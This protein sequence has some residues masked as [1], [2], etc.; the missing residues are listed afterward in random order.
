MVRSTAGWVVAIILILLM[1]G[2]G[3]LK[4]FPMYHSVFF[5]HFVLVPFHKAAI[6]ELITCRDVGDLDEPETGYER[7]PVCSWW[8]CAEGDCGASDQDIALV[9]ACDVVSVVD[10]NC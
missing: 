10:F 6:L 1:D 3:V 2:H 5:F 4:T 7:R 9:S 8:E